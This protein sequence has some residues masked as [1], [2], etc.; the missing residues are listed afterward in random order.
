MGKCL[1]N[2]KQI[3]HLLRSYF[4]LFFCVRQCLFE[5]FT[6]ATKKFDFIIK[7][8]RKKKKT[9]MIYGGIKANLF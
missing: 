2:L 6:K 9:S 3:G 1:K 5:I 8:L 7:V 4:S